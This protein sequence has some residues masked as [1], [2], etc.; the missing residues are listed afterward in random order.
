MIFFKQAKIPFIIYNVNK[1]QT[2]F[3]GELRVAKNRN[4]LDILHKEKNGTILGIFRNLKLC[5]MY[6]FRLTVL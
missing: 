3:T 2:L 1:Y 6:L 5:K 4:V